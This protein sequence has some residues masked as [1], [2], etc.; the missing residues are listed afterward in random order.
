[1]STS[2]RLSTN[3]A[4]VV[5]STPPLGFLLE[6]AGLAEA[7][8]CRTS[9]VTLSVS[10]RLSQA[11]NSSTM[12]SVTL[13]VSSRLSQAPNSSTMESGKSQKPSASMRRFSRLSPMKYPKRRDVSKRSRTAHSRRR[14]WHRAPVDDSVVLEMSTFKCGNRYRCLLTGWMD[15]RD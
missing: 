2:C 3:L 5:T 12:E 13:S 1:M 4:L 8:L 11:P 9:P 6:V 10:S 14:H 7:V 15:Q